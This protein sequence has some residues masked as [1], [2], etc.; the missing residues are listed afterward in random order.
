MRHFLIRAAL[1]GVAGVLI[2]VLVTGCQLTGAEPAPLTPVGATTGGLPTQEP[3]QEQLPPTPTDTGPIDVFGTQTAQAPIPTEEPVTAEP[4]TEP[5]GAVEPT[6]EPGVVTPTPMVQPTTAPGGSAE[7]PATHTVAAGENLFRIALRYGLST[8]QLAAANGI[9]NPASI[10]VGQ[11]LRIPG[12]EDPGTTTGGT[13]TGTTDPGTGER[14][15]VVAAGEN[16]Y[17]IALQYG[18]TWQRLAEY[19]GITNPASLRVGQVLRI[20]GN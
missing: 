9:T 17:R 5:G 14:T 1:T 2:A 20:P 7:C 18:L 19:N 8:E 10:V 11:V 13:G 16:L 6:A 15:H 4:T 12:C 3:T